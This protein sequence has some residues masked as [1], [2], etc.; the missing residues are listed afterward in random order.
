ME[1]RAPL[2]GH[3]R[4]DDAGYRRVGGLPKNSRRGTSRLRLHHPDYHARE[5]PTIWTRW[6]PALTIPST[7][8]STETG[9]SRACVWQC[10]FLICI[11]ACA[12]PI[13]TSS[14]GLKS[15]LLNWKKRFRRKV[16]FFP[17]PVTSY[18]PQ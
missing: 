18:A 11:K 14:V 3:L 12:S 17:A 7:N 9:S 16:N 1:T 10:A 4:L 15:E 2:A 5:K 13:P 6:I 8:G